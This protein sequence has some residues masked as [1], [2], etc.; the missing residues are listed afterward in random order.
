MKL[1]SITIAIAIA[2]API[3]T[4]A[5]A[6]PA[7]AHVVKC[8]A[9]SAYAPQWVGGDTY[10]SRGRIYCQPSIWDAN[11]IQRIRQTVGT[12]YR[13][14]GST[15]WYAASQPNRAPWSNKAEQ[16]HYHAFQC[17]RGTHDYRTYSTLIVDTATHVSINGRIVR[18]GNRIV[19]TT[20]FSTPRRI[21]C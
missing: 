18:L 21:V 4:L 16:N 10:R 19:E 7:E 17:R 11:H 9:H 8:M 13:K 12:Q 5:P 6:P 3:A 20:K 15:L 2:I 14:P 1:R